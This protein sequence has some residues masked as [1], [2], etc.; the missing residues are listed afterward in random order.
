MTLQLVDLQRKT[1]KNI[2]NMTK[3]TSLAMTF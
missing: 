1:L 3:V 2:T